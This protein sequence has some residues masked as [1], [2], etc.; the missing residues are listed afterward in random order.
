M[1]IDTFI[2]QNAHA[3]ACLAFRYDTGAD[4]LPA[5]LSSSTPRDCHSLH[6]LEPAQLQVYVACLRQHIAPRQPCASLGALLIGLS[7]AYAWLRALT[8]QL[9]L[10]AIPEWVAPARFQ[11]ETTKFW[12]QPRDAVRF[13]AEMIQ[14]VPILIYGSRPR[15]SGAAQR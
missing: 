9:Q 10:A 11:R 1:A 2:C 8:Q 12:L 5:S 6:E 4:A 7:D 13:K 15:L 14:H 3:A